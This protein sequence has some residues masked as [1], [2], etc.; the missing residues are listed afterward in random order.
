MTCSSQ[1]L[2][3]VLDRSLEPPLLIGVS[4]EIDSIDGKDVCRVHVEP[5]PSPCSPL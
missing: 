1:T 5:S 4:V 2:H 3:Q